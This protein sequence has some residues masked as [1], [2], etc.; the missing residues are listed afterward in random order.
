MIGTVAGITTNPMQ[1][2]GHRD[3]REMIISH[4]Q[5]ISSTQSH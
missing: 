1:L 5:V 3:L 2:E 4:P